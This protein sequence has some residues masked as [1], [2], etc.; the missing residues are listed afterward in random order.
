MVKLILSHKLVF[1]LIFL[2]MLTVS[3]TLY[4][5]TLNK[6]LKRE[7]ECFILSSKTEIQN[8]QASIDSL[9]QKPDSLQNYKVF[10]RDLKNVE[11]ENKN[12][13]SFL[14]RNIILLKNNISI[15]KDD[16]IIKKVIVF[17]DFDSNFIKVPFKES[18]RGIHVS[19]KTSYEVKTKIKGFYLNI[20]RDAYNIQSY[21]YFNPV[22]STVSNTISIDGEKIL[23]STVLDASL[24]KLILTGLPRKK[25]F[26]DQF[27]G[28]VN[29]I[30][31]K[32]TNLDLGA[33]ISYGFFNN[34]SISA[35]RSFANW[36]IKAEYSK[37][38]HDWLK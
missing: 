17:K 3:S 32:D 9:K 33:F 15:L 29:L 5:Y 16:T 6:S 2:I 22:D 10:V 26:L 1:S 36:E 4:F 11:V 20:S 12:L 38:L 19:G 14:N 30:Y 7:Y 24:H 31:N 21:L 35:S 34:Y 27:E 25:S 13:I 37:T 28:G 8:K 18:L 23:S